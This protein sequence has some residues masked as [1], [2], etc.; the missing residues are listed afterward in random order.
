[1]TTE[2]SHNP[3]FLPGKMAPEGFRVLE[4][5]IIYELPIP[6]KENVGLAAVLDIGGKMPDP[7]FEYGESKERSSVKESDFTMLLAVDL[8]V[9]GAEKWVEGC[10]IP[11]GATAALIDPKGMKISPDGKVNEGVTFLAPGGALIIGRG[12]YKEGDPQSGFRRLSVDASAVSYKHL[13]IA[14]DKSGTLAIRDRY[15]T[16]GTLVSTGEAARDAV[17]EI[18][19]HHEHH[20]RFKRVLGEEATEQ[21]LSIPTA[22]VTMQSLKDAEKRPDNDAAV[23][24]LASILGSNGK[25][26]GGLGEEL[27]KLGPGPEDIRRALPRQVRPK[28]PSGLRW[29]YGH[30]NCI[31][32][33][34]RQGNLY[35]VRVSWR[36]GQKRLRRV[37]HGW[38]KRPWKVLNMSRRLPMTC[39][40]VILH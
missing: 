13:D 34:I 39:S 6:P 30:D 23:K 2:Q 40:A 14:V 16:N 4:K 1:M 27:R 10:D 12:Q 5:G 11:N 20:M 18:G 21:V 9:D 36:G 26:G 31:K 32:P 24:K 15:S 7:T 38:A 37:A 8:R 29:N 35:F 22:E 3:N 17:N 25:G 28:M 19:E 33:R